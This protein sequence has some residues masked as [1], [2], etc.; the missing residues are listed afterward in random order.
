MLTFMPPA[1]NQRA[2]DEQKPSQNAGEHKNGA[3]CTIDVHP[4]CCTQLLKFLSNVHNFILVI[5]L[6]CAH[7]ESV[8]EDLETTGNG[9]IRLRVFLHENMQC[10][11]FSKQKPPAFFAVVP[12]A[13]TI[14]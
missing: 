6:V 2:E 5:P 13:A 7:K 8:R 10:L 4:C 14:P 12:L 9:A 3:N 1:K 11:P